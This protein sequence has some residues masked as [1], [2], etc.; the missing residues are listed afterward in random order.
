MARATFGPMKDV[1]EKK[2]FADTDSSSLMAQVKELETDDFQAFI[3]FMIAGK[4]IIAAAEEGNIDNFT[5]AF[6]QCEHKHLAFWHVQQAF[7]VA[8]KNKHLFI[9]EHIIE[10]MGMTLNHEAFTGFFH[11]YIF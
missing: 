7:K 1:S 8:C 11:V 3:K 10:D 6:Y 2:Y 5:K 9:I 4:A